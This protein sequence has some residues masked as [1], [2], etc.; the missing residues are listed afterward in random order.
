V[1]YPLVTTDWLGEHLHEEDL[2]IVDCRF[3]LDDPER[4]RV[5]YAVGHI[6]SASYMSLKDDLT[7]PSGPGRHPL[8]EAAAFAHRLGSIGIGSD[9]TVVAYDSSGGSIAARLWWML[10]S[11][12]HERAFVLDGGWDAWASEPRSVTREVPRWPP[13]AFTAV[14]SWRG[15]TDREQLD[16]ATDTLILLDARAP[17]RYRGEHEPLDPVAGHIPG[18]INIPYQGNTDETGRFLTPEALADRFAIAASEGTVVCYCGSGVTAC[19]NLLALEVAGFEGALLY[20]GSWSDWCTTGGEVR[21][22]DTP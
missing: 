8:P 17:E 6:P 14:D 12:G 3:Y 5:E 20:P 16:G 9:H 1:P 21:T 22:S 19:N 13:D 11:L 7:G 10:R 18:A 2:R 4:G 15:V